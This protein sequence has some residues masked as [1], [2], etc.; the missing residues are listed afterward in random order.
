MFKCRDDLVPPPEK[1]WEMRETEW[2]FLTRGRAINV[3]RKSKRRTGVSLSRGLVAN[4]ETNRMAGEVQDSN[5]HAPARKTYER[6]RLSVAEMLA[7]ASR[8]YAHSMDEFDLFFALIK[9]KQILRA[10]RKNTVMR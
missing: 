2:R 8:K 6:M 4:D 7:V 9:I 1:G 5:R 10:R 3:S